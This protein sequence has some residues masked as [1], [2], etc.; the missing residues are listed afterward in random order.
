VAVIILKKIELSDKT[1]FDSFFDKG[2]YNNSECTFTYHFMWRK[3][4]NIRWGIAADCLCLILDFNGRP[5]AL[6]PYGAENG[7]FG[8]ALAAIE[9]YF[10]AIDKPFYMRGITGQF[11][12]LFNSQAPERYVLTP[13]RESFDYIYCG[14]NLR[15]L[16]GRRYSGKRNHIN[17]FMKEHG[18]YRYDSINEANLPA[19]TAYVA[20]WF[21][22]HPPSRYLQAEQQATL[23]LLQHYSALELRGALIEID[24][25]IAAMT[26]GESLSATTAVIHTEKASV[27]IRGLYQVIN[28]EFC[29]RQWADKL[30]INREEDL[31][32]EGLRTAKLSYYPCLMLEKYQAVPVDVENHSG[33]GV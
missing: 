4:G 9:D 6:P 26:L 5:F 1:V 11:L 30:Y 8:E 33:R 17:A 31:G 10:R 27:A 25:K 29:R 19:C 16:A 32:V 20:E 23:E 13:S 18:D 21:K 22:Q 24:G 15:E 2:Q 3:A 12:S 14:E 7:N 28:Q